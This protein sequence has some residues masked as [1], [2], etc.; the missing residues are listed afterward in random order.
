MSD[1][2]PVNAGRLRQSVARWCFGD[3]PANRFYATLQELG[4]VGVD[5][6]DESEWDTAQHYG[7]TPC[8]IMGGGSFGPPPIGSDRMFGGAIG[9]N[10]PA[11]HAALIESMQL[12]IAKA[13]QN[14][15]PAIIGLFGDRQ[16]RDDETGIAHCV[17][18]ISQVV[19]LLEQHGVMLAL[20]LLNSRVDHPDYQGDNSAFGVEV[21]RRLG[22]AN[23]KLVYDAYHMQI[24]EGNLIS[25]LRQNI[26]YIGHIHVAG[27]PGRHEIDERQEVNWRAVATAIADLGFSGYVGHEWIPT[28]SDPL[29]DLARAVAT[30]TV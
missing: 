30:L 16:G 1:N 26:D 15:L 5:L 8:M 9:W 25:T 20:E 19:P 13:A 14:G 27:V 4:V 2:A 10:D 22:S 12:Q 11:N 18:G 6:A 23:V 21:C 7:I 29:A 3:I 28:G 24:M 17:A